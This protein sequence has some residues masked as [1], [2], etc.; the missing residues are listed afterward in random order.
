VTHDKHLKKRIREEAARMECSYQQALESRWW[1][2]EERKLRSRL[3]VAIRMT[4]K[5]WPS[6]F[7]PDDQAIDDLIGCLLD[8][9]FEGESRRYIKPLPDQSVGQWKTLLCMRTVSHL[10]CTHFNLADDQE[11]RAKD[12]T[13]AVAP[14]VVRRGPDHAFA[15]DEAQLTDAVAHWLSDDFEFE[16][17]T[18]S[19]D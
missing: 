10:A 3:S 9:A 7:V 17:M 5:T 6:P 18:D 12:L 4:I 13:L 16:Q 8:V 14:I 2:G 11:A 15:R 1:P 19:D